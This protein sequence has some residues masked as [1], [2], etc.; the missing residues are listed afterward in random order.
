VVEDDPLAVLGHDQDLHRL[1][2]VGR[3]LGGQQQGRQ[4]RKGEHG[5]LLAAR[6]TLRVAV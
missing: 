5:G 4:Q 1:D 6:E 3:Q 2:G